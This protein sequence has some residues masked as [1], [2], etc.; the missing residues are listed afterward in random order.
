MLLSC[1]SSEPRKELNYCQWSQDSSRWIGHQPDWSKAFA[2]ALFGEKD[3]AS[4]F[5][6]GGMLTRA[7]MF[8]NQ[9]HSI[10]IVTNNSGILSVEDLTSNCYLTPQAHYDRQVGRFNYQDLVRM[11][12][13][14]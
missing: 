12:I 4:N 11:N 7:R 13:F 1:A 8:D 9:G 2:A 3:T 14:K 10:E 5:V 6:T